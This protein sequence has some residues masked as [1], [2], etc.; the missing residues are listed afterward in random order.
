M[1]NHWTKYHERKELLMF[2]NMV[3]KNNGC[4]RTIVSKE[5]KKWLKD[6]LKSLEGQLVKKK[7]KDKYRLYRIIKVEGLDITFVRFNKKGVSKQKVVYLPSTRSFL[8]GYR[9]STSITFLNKLELATEEEL[10]LWK[11]EAL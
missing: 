2:E 5:N 6:N 9:S 7:M 1:S 8:R 10:D 4:A 3:A 11:L